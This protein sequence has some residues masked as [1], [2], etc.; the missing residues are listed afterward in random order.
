MNR[1]V[2]AAFLLAV[3]STAHSG[4]LRRQ[5]R[6]EKAA[7][8]VL[9][10]NGPPRRVVEEAVLGFYVTQFQQS[11]QAGEVTNE[12]FAKI[13]P[14]LQQF[15]HDRFE[16]S[17]R[18]TRALNQLRQAVARNAADDELKRLVRDLDLADAEFQLNQEKFFTN[19]DPLLN[20]RQQARMRI[21][22]NM[23]DNRIRQILNAVQAPPAQPRPNAAAP[24]ATNPD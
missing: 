7:Q 4:P 1:I 12:L 22:Q 10:P 2:L 11:V 19:V 14:F 5:Q 13:L 21:L 23:A 8:Q 6:Q 17:Q 18:R 20:A 16:I 24:P 3:V 15:V 9:R